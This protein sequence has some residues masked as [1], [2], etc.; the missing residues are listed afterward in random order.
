LTVNCDQRRYTQSL[1]RVGARCFINTKARQSDFVAAACAVCVLVCCANNGAGTQPSRV[2]RALLRLG[3]FI[4]YNFPFGKRGCGDAS[5]SAE[6][7]RKRRLPLCVCVPT[8]TLREFCLY[9]FACN[10][11][12]PRAHGRILIAHPQCL[13]VQEIILLHSGYCVT[14]HPK[15]ACR[16]P[17]MNEKRIYYR[18]LRSR[19]ARSLSR[20]LFYVVTFIY[21]NHTDAAA[22]F[23]S[24]A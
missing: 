17:V 5:S 14:G 1:L 9:A 19:L 8:C 16:R 6:I 22:A 11:N 13:L 7:G 24:A 15:L 18:S 3:L 4:Y 21:Y 20:A 12:A 23:V 10:M 2:H